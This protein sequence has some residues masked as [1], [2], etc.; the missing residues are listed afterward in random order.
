M[1]S[2]CPSIISCET[3]RKL[4]VLMLLIFR[5]IQN[6]ISI[7]LQ[8]NFCNFGVRWGGVSWIPIECQLWV[9]GEGHCVFSV[10][11]QR[12]SLAET[13]GVSVAERRRVALPQW[14]CDSATEAHTVSL[15]SWLRH[16]NA[17]CVFA[18]ETKCFRGEDEVTLLTELQSQYSLRWKEI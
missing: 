17:C 11:R 13:Q 15:T 10:E 12:A 18:T 4:F 16:R 14:L 8:I 3:W 5:A 2:I 9:H 6:P 7:I 1:L